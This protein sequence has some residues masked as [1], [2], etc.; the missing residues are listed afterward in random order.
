MFVCLLDVATR[1][2]VCI[3]EMP[4]E[5]IGRDTVPE[6]VVEEV[7]DVCCHSD[8]D[9]VSEANFVAAGIQ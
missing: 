3:V 9:R 6:E 4:R 1:L 7:A 8:T 2:S 5:F